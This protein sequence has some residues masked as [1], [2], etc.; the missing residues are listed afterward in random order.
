MNRYLQNT[1]FILPL[2]FFTFF[3]NAQRITITAPNGGEKLYLGQM[4]IPEARWTSTGGITYVK[5][6]ISYDG[7]SS[8]KLIATDVPNNGIARWY[9]PPDISSSCLFRISDVKDP[10]VSDISNST[11][12]IAPS[13][14]TIKE[15]I[16]G[17]KYTSCQ[18]SSFDDRMFIRWVNNGAFNH[19]GIYFS[20]DSGSTWS[21]ITHDRYN[22]PDST[23]DNYYQISIPRVRSNK[24][25]IKV[26]ENRRIDSYD[27]YSGQSMYALSG[28]FSIDNANPDSIRIVSPTPGQVLKTGDTHTIKVARYG[29][30]PKKL[31]A[32]ISSD[33]ARWEDLAL[34]NGFLNY[35]GSTFYNDSIIW[36]IPDVVSDNYYIKVMDETGC[37]EALSEGPFSVSPVSRIISVS[38]ASSG[39]TY[40]ASNPTYVSWSTAHMESKLVD[41][42]FS[43]DSGVTWTT[44]ANRV[45]NNGS[46]QWFPP[47]INSDKCLYRVTDHFNPFITNTS[48]AP[49]TIA[50]P[51]VNIIS[52]KAN[53]V[54]TFGSYAFVTFTK[55][56]FGS[57]LNLLL[58]TD[59]GTTWQELGRNITSTT[60]GYTWTV[61]SIA[62]DNCILQ[63]EDNRNPAFAAYSGVFSIVQPHLTIVEPNGGRSYEIC[64][65]DTIRWTSNGTTTVDLSYSSDGGLSWVSIATGRNTVKGLNKYG[66]KY[67]CII[68]DKFLVKITDRGSFNSDESNATFS[69]FQGENGLKLTYPTGGE[70]MET[71]SVQNI[72]WDRM[73]YITYVT[74][75]YS[76]NGGVSWSN[77]AYSTLNEGE[78]KWT[79]PSTISENW[80][81]RVTD[82]Q[83]QCLY[84]Q[85]KTTFATYQRPY[86]TVTSPNGGELWNT[87]VTKTITWT[88]GYTSGNFNMDY[89][90]DGGFTWINIAANQKTTSYS[91][92]TPPTVS[93]NCLVRVSDASNPAV[94]DVSN[95]VFRLAIPAITL[96]APAQGASVPKCSVYPI[97][98]NSSAASTAVRIQ[99]STNDG[100]TWIT[101][102]N[103]AT[104]REGSNT[105]NWTVPEL[106][107][108]QALLRIVD[109]YNSSI[110]DTNAISFIEGLPGITVTSPLRGELLTSGTQ[111]LITWT[112]VQPFSYAGIHYSTDGGLSWSAIS[113]YTSN[114]GS[115]SWTVPDIESDKYLVKV[116]DYNAQCNVSQSDTFRVKVDP[117][118]TITTPNGGDNWYA[119]TKQVI[120]WKSAGISD[121]I[122]DLDYS[123]DGGQTWKPIAA[124][125]KNTLSYIWTIPNEP[126][127][128]S[129]IRVSQN[130]NPSVFDIPDRSFTIKPS[131]INLIAPEGP[132]NLSGC[133]A[134]AIQWNNAGATSYV[135]LHY[136]LNNGNNWILIKNSVLS[137]TGMNSYTWVTPDTNAT[138]VLVKIADYSYP[139]FADTTNI[140]FSLT[141][142]TDRSLVIN[143]PGSSDTLKS[144]ERTTI[145]WTST[146]TINKINLAYSDNGTSWTNFGVN[147]NNTGSTDWLVPTSLSGN[148]YIRISDEYGCVSSTTDDPVVAKQVPQITI[149]N[150]T[151]AT[152]FKAG[153][154]QNVAWT[155]RFITSGFVVIESSL[156]SGK[157]WGIVSSKQANN[158][159]YSWQVPYADS[160][161][162]FIRISDFADANV[163]GINSKPFTVYIPKYN[164]LSPNGGEK[165]EG[166]SEFRILSTGPAS[167]KIVYSTDNGK[168]WS[169][170]MTLG[171]PDTEN[172]V[173]YVTRWNVPAVNSDSCLIKAF[174]SADTSFYD[175]SDKPFT[176]VSDG[177]VYYQVTR[178]GTGDTLMGAT[179]EK[180]VFG[181]NVPFRYYDYYYSA[182]NGHNWTL[183]YS[184]Y[185][186]YGLYEKYIDW[187]VPDV[188]SD[189]YIIA[190]TES[191]NQCM[192]AQSNPFAVRTGPRLKI[193]APAAGAIWFTQSANYINWESYRITSAF[194]SLKYSLDG[195]M[196]WITINE[197]AANTGYY[198]WNLPDQDSE[199]CILKVSEFENPAVF[200]EQKIVIKRPFYL[201]SPIGGEIYSNCSFINIRWRKPGPS[202]SLDLDYSLDNGQTWQSI[203]KNYQNISYQGVTDEYSYYW[204]IPSAFSNQCL[205]KVSQS[206]NPLGYD[207]SRQ[208]FSIVQNPDL[209]LSVLNP[210]GGERFI[211]GERTHI[212]WTTTGRVNFVNL[213]YSSNGGNN[214][215]IIGDTT[216]TFNYPWSI[217]DQTSSS[218]QVKIE[219][220]ENT[221]VSGV[222][223]TPF[224]VSSFKVWPGDTDENGIVNIYDF[225][226]I[227]L[228]YGNT[229]TARANASLEWSSQQSAP[230][231]QNQ[232]NGQDIMAIDCN[233]DGII[234][235]A[236]TSTISANY[237]LTRS[238]DLSV[239]TGRAPGSNPTDPLLYFELVERSSSDDTVHVQLMAGEPD[240]PVSDLY[241]LAFVIDYNQEAI[242]EGSVSLQWSGNWLAP[243][244]PSSL[245]FSKNPELSGR[246]EGVVSKTNHTPQSGYGKIAD[247][248]MAIN[249]N[250]PSPWLMLSVSEYMAINHSGEIINLSAEPLIIDQVVTSAGRGA[251]SQ[252]FSVYPNPSNGVFNVRIDTRKQATV[253]VINVL[254]EEV[255]KTQLNNHKHIINLKDAAK[256]LYFIQIKTDKN[257]L[258]KSVILY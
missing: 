147:V 182:D 52:P 197:K 239:T 10:S 186:D 7:G 224:V 20:S 91:W 51:A 56:N 248:K 191:N 2:L 107:H 29:G 238:S 4:S 200:A 77:I 247:L 58:S 183:F 55:N 136:S 88:S 165:L 109:Y 201:T 220:K 63:Y 217:P 78:Y 112:S 176:I 28:V 180:V 179:E 98:W 169:R 126:S 168:T 118:I 149:T 150:I 188:A 254:G 199:N 237:G 50:L 34:T 40:Y 135:N 62:S 166:C 158:G 38:P 171:S 101:I 228:Y 252:N 89:S 37:V 69:T 151:A 146:G 215:T 104:N 209:S 31:K 160:Y 231:N 229:G 232:R 17:A 16:A 211:A 216:N 222:N 81:L 208:T 116:Y 245:T 53:D 164:V 131:G 203:V 102:N 251:D 219:D 225:L 57:T 105:L 139:A 174:D 114:T 249:K 154:T 152:R 195:G 35:R 177:P 64:T 134:V 99:Y 73:G 36:K 137:S 70:R 23:P 214:W 103:A 11:F 66:W 236:D 233:G 65:N 32:H 162:C 132:G 39:Y 226:P 178:P 193:T 42:A 155:S 159:S 257:T 129:L 72:T 207:I 80:L 113:A 250:N 111:K 125:V 205:I 25:L 26:A 85:T 153:T 223:N 76:T 181:T 227:G 60:A 161:N 106:S 145:S 13:S 75:Q 68:S 172:H 83:G 142:N 22:Y 122:F 218:F 141:K 45:V 127:S 198:Q 144:G 15:P 41:L 130:G 71:G 175:I 157:T 140:P 5:L 246:V 123:T 143:K 92:L 184:E 44:I 24:C 170:I 108:E 87:G 12:S 14:I 206:L 46:Y 9:F 94:Y 156:D 120:Y 82:Q 18:A 221:C 212:N 253:S 128:N 27:Y 244:W 213:Y 235:A 96:T 119:G 3:V 121:A 93:N 110:G 8:W 194:V 6:E 202:T 47:Y 97:A 255:Y 185:K 100:A 84:D 74:I 133:G 48:G 240:S 148:Y 90:L 210:T 30:A 79:V 230:W 196:S 59:G 190:V 67:P 189:K 204:K 43:P 54:Y 167:P 117:K 124:A 115:Y 49:F 234:N 1:L 241:G 163:F 242:Q 61:P 86:I 187:M 192:T 243:A 173:G 258:T 19:V 256:G 95:A 21:L 33:G 138:S